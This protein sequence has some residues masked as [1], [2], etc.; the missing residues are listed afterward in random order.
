MFKL[1]LIIAMIDKEAHVNQEIHELEARIQTTS[2]KIIELMEQDRKDRLRLIVLR[3]K[4]TDQLTADP[5][6]VR[7]DLSGN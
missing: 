5:S 1:Y 6:C 4:Q 7:W 2:R 3:R